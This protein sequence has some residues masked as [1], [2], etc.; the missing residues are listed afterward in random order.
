[1]IVVDW[2][3]ALSL[4]MVAM[5]LG[6]IIG[7]GLGKRIQKR[8][9]NHVYDLALFCP[10]CGKQHLDIGEFASRIHRTHLCENTPDGPNTVCGKLWRPFDFPTRGVE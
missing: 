7:L 9:W 8:R 3:D 1:M 2:A 4:A 5:M 10:N 6:V